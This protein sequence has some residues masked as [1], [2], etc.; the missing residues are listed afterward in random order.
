MNLLIDHLYNYSELEES[1]LMQ[2]DINESG[3]VE[4]TDLYLLVY[5]ITGTLNN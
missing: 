5:Q 1:V 3:E 4:I 2:A